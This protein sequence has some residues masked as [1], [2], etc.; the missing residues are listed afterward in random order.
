MASTTQQHAS[1]HA[2]ACLPLSWKHDG[3]Q[4]PALPQSFIIAQAISTGGGPLPRR[5]EEKKL[6]LRF[7]IDNS[8]GMGRDKGRDKAASTDWWQEDWHQLDFIYSWLMSFRC[9]EF[10][11]HRSLTDPRDGLTHV[12]NYRSYG[13]IIIRYIKDRSAQTPTILNDW[14]HLAERSGERLT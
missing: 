7:P 6:V 8:G 3:A 9:F 5:G 13:I 11:D 12:H 1:L 2:Q 10:Y 4:A 14:V